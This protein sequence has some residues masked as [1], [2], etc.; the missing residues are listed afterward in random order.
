MRRRWAR[1]VASLLLGVA[2]VALCG[3][4]ISL[5]S[6]P[7]VST[8][9]GGSTY[10][11]RAEFA[12]VLNLP[13]D[14]QV[15]I[16]AQV[17]GQ[18]GAISTSHYRADLTLDIDR[19]VRLPTRTTAQVRFDNPLGD[20][21]V[22]LQPPTIVTV[23]AAHRARFLRPGA[24]ISR[25]RDQHRA[26]RGGHIRRAVPGAQRRGHQPAR[27]DRRASSTRPSPGTNPRSGPSSRPSPAAWARWP[28]AVRRSTA[29]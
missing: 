17:V 6:L 11:L 2:S 25:E 18:V 5:Q 14:A 15:R 26:E 20:E 19:G 27:D 22:L 21:Y 1:R 3:C 24:T 23:S 16:G 12:N 10:P 4:A 9:G 28:V 29:R 13:Q 7:K 8:V